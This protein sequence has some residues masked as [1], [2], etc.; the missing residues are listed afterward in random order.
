M[1][2]KRCNNLCNNRRKNVTIGVTIE[3]LLQ[4]KM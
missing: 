3:R 4:T 2:E 1:F